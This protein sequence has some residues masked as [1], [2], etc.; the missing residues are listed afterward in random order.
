[1]PLGPHD[2]QRVF[3]VATRNLALSHKASHS[4]FPLVIDFDVI[5]DIATVSRNLATADRRTLGGRSIFCDP[6]Q[7]VDCVNRLLNQSIAGKPGEVVPVANHPLEIRDVLRT[8][9]RWRHRLHWPC[10]IGP[11]NGHDVTDFP[12]MNSLEEFPTR[13]VVA[14]AEA[15][16]HPEFLF[17]GNLD[18]FNDRTDTGS[19]GR[20][21]LFGEDMLSRF[22]GGSQVIRPKSWRRCEQNHIAGIDQLLVAFESHEFVFIGYRH[23]LGDSFVGLQLPQRVLDRLRKHVGNSRQLDLR[24]CGQCLLSGTGSASPAADESHLQLITSRSIG[25]GS[26]RQI[27]SDGS[28]NGS[29]GLEK[30]ASGRCNRGIRVRHGFGLHD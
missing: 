1:M 16:D 24:I 13:Q 3:A 11:V 7:P 20:H 17:L 8:T 25:P 2:I 27:Q 4:V 22:D 5:E 15:C 30:V 14:P 21:W 26:H 29:A 6:L 28:S 9:A 19:I 12:T 23:L 18:R 10:Q